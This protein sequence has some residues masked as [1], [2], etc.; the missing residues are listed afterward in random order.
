MVLTREGAVSSNIA[1]I[2][3]P[4]TVLQG[5]PN[6]KYPT[7]I[8]YM[9]IIRNLKNLSHLHPPHLQSRAKLGKIHLAAILHR[10]PGRARQIRT[11][12]HRL[13]QLI[14]CRPTAAVLMA[15][16]GQQAHSQPM[17]P[18]KRRAVLL[19]PTAIPAQVRTPGV[20]ITE[21]AQA[22][23]RN[24]QH[25][26]EDLA[27]LEKGSQAEQVT[28]HNAQSAVYE[29]RRVPAS[30]LWSHF[31]LRRKACSCFST[32]TMRLRRSGRAVAL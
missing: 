30:L 2:T 15:L 9:P 14:P 18:M 25:W 32:T 31:C 26:E 20:P 13:W 8:S 29:C 11:F 19:H 24:N 5:Y 17:V 21:V 28:S 4:L 6:R 23:S 12:H 3:T 16:Q 22:A 1:A 27:N 10:I 7:S